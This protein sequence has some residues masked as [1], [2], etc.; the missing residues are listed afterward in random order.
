M[1]QVA[2]QAT[3]RHMWAIKGRIVALASDRTVSPSEDSVFAGRVW[4]GDDGRIAAVTQ[5][6]ASPDRPAP[7]APASSTSARRWS[8]P[9]LI[10]LHNHLAYNTLPLWTEPSQTTPFAHHN[11]WTRAE[12]YAV[13]TTWPAYALITACPQELLA[14]V[15]TKALV[16]GTTSIQGS[17]PKNHPR[18]GWLVRNV[19]D[20]TFGIGEP[21]LIY[22]SVLTALPAD[23]GRPGQLDEH[24]KAVF[25][26]HCAEGQPG[27]IVARE[28][29]DAER[30]GCLQSRF[31]AVHANAADP[32]AFDL[33]ARTGRDRL[34][35]VL[36]PLALRHDHRRPGRPSRRHAASAWVRTGHRPAPSTCSAS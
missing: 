17:P 7:T 29:T 28:F 27:T 8:C 31:V 3:L 14:Y 18:D 2:D 33:L 26:Y 21:N 20:E 30:A 10:D 12:S 22:A 23:A 9:G 25:I 11:S 36:Q 4:I 16:G 15:E 13:R 1:Y 32:A 35:A 24:N 6:S 19:E 34:V 5:G